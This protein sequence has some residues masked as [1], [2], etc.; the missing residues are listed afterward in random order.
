MKNLIV[1][2]SI[3]LALVS[4]T[5]APDFLSQTLTLAG[6]NRPQLERVIAHYDSIGDPEKQAAARYLIENMAGHY[7]YEGSRIDEY[8]TI[9]LSLARSGM[10]P[11]AQY[12]SLLALSRG[13]FADVP[14]H[15]V[16]DAKVVRADYLIRNIDAAFAAWR[17]NRFAEHLTFSEFCEWLLPYKC[18]ERQSL[19]AWRDT[20]VAHYGASLAEWQPNDES[21]NSTFRA[22]EVVREYVLDRLGRFEIY[23]DAPIELRSA[24]TMVNLRFGRCI[25]FVTL[26]TMAFRSLGLPVV[27]DEVPCYGRFRAGHA[28]FTLLNDRGEELPSEWDL[29]TTPGKAFFTNY[30]FP[31]VVRNSYRIDNRRLK[32]LNRSVMKYPFDIHQTDVTDHY[33][34]TSD[35]ELP[36][37]EGFRRVED[38]AYLAVFDGHYTIW[39]VVEFGEVS[40]NTMKFSNIGRNIMYLAMGFDGERLVPLTKPFIVHK[41]GSLSYIDGADGTTESIDIRRKYFQSE[42]VVDMRRRLLGGRIQAANSPTFADA[43]DIY[44][45]TDEYIPDKIPTKVEKPYR[46][47]RYLG[48]DGTFGSI[49]ELAF[50]ADTAKLDGRNI[51]CPFAQKEL[52]D[53]AFDNN[54]LT[55]FE[56]SAGEHDKWLVN[57]DADATGN[58]DGAWVGRDFGHAQR[59]DYVRVIPRSDDNDIHPGDEYELFFWNNAEWLSLGRQTAVGNTL[60][61]DR[62]PHGA[63]LWVKD[64]TQGWDERPFLYN[65]GKPVWW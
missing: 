13:E 57:S 59:V 9:A 41:D 65:D 22:L 56:T 17:G 39:R 27:I 16:Q 52:I 31:K 37:P 49:A 8:Y 7:S 38:Y 42:K 45:I 51:A 44:T 40:D 30:T 35:I 55:N 26:G 58:A 2:L 15:T 32:Y 43:A 5:T 3:A 60:H 34:R 50:F 46:Y 29:S 61:Y 48:A 23:T 6:E 47:W 14:S 18:C 33:V 21:Y 25:D 4:C 36:V 63:L 1:S 54:W 53:K 11:D 10:A 20:M 12:D 19:D 24:E 64:Y 62:V 28:W